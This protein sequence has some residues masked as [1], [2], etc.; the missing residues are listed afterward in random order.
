MRKA[1]YGVGILGFRSLS[2]PDSTFDFNIPGNIVAFSTHVGLHQMPVIITS[3]LNGCTLCINPGVAV[4]DQ[5][6]TAF[7]FDAVSSFRYHDLTL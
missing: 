4:Y 2:I 7:A 5:S 1:E 3:S 6:V